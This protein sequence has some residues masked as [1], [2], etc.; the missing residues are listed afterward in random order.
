MQSASKTVVF[1]LDFDDKIGLGHLSRCSYLAT[2]LQTL[3][4]RTLLLLGP[5]TNALKG[6]AAH[7]LEAFSSHHMLSGPDSCVQRAE[8]TFLDKLSGWHPDLIVL[9]HYGSSSDFVAAIRQSAPVLIIEDGDQRLD[10]DYILAYGSSGASFA[11]NSKILARRLVGSKFTLAKGFS[12]FRIEDLSSDHAEVTVSLGGGS[13]DAQGVA[14]AKAVIENIG[15]GYGYLTGRGLSS[16]GLS[17]VGPKEAFRGRPRVKLSALLSKSRRAIVTGGVSLMEALAQGIPSIAFVTAKNQ[18]DGLE[19]FQDLQDV[20]VADSLE[21][22][23]SQEFQM[24]WS[25]YEEPSE[26]KRAELLLRSTVDSFGPLR[27]AMAV[28]LCDSTNVSLRRASEADLPI[29]LGWRRELDASSGQSSAGAIQAA[30]HLEWFA[31][32]KREG[33]L[34]WIAEITGLPVGQV[35]IHRDQESQREVLSYSVDQ[36]FRGRGIGTSL[37]NQALKRAEF[38]NEVW[39]KVHASNIPSLK[40]LSNSGFHFMEQ[41]NEGFI[42]MLWT[43]GSSSILGDENRA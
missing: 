37:L 24:W 22:F 21:F 2:A 28:G 31:Q 13:T 16:S 5:G 27:V 34:I 36:L 18:L 7:F 29:L 3:G 9:D 14:V 6:V 35:R 17:F 1:R 26:R 25:R 42:W 43:P 12:D 19:R 11:P 41:G 30:E 40:T 8:S 20:L 4:H 10:A 33:A 32:M 23:S 39:A 38:Q 15:S